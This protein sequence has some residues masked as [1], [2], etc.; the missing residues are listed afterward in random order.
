MVQEVSYK[1]CFTCSNQKKMLLFSLHFLI[2]T[3]FNIAKV[4][5]LKLP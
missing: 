5:I 1:K 2:K 4:A 3:K